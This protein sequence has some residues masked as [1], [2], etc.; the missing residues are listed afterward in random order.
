[1]GNKMRLSPHIGINLASVIRIEVKMIIPGQ[2][3]ARP[4]SKTS[5]PNL[6]VCMIVL[7]AILPPM[8]AYCTCDHLFKD[9]GKWKPAEICQALRKNL[10]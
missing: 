6:P 1:M 9:L 8:E 10:T 7:W 5:A 4:V 3:T 2:Q